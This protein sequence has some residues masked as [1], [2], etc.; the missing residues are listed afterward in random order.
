V[1]V[2]FFSPLPPART[3]VADYAETLLGALRTH[4]DVIV[5]AADADVNLYHIGNN[6]LHSAIYDRALAYPG[7][8]V[9]HDAVLQHFFLGQLTQQQYTD[10]FIFTTSSF[11]IMENGPASSPKICGSIALVPPRSRAIS[12]GPC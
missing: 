12:R 1:T 8:V 9:L 4:G 2:G 7:I 11:S 10:E 3:G 5:D 6:R